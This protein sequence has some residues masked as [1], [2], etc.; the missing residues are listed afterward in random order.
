MDIV[1]LAL[2]LFIV[3]GMLGGLYFLSNRAKRLS[4]IPGLRPI[5]FSSLMKG[6]KPGP[7]PHP[8]DE[9]RL[10]RRLHLTANHQLHFLALNGSKI[11]LCTHP[12]GCQ[13]LPFP[14]SVRTDV[15]GRPDGEHHAG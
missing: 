13:V 12:Q 14:Q 5:S 6:R 11:L 3:F 10:L 15:A 1:R 2:A 7:V 9:V 8:D 4:G